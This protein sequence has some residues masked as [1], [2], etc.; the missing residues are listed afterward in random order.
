MER[1][2]TAVVTA[3]NGG[4]LARVYHDYDGDHFVD[5][6]DFA[7][8]RRCWGAALKIGCAAF[9]YD[10][11]KIIDALDWATFADELGG[12]GCPLD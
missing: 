2:E 11:N 6:D 7:W 3:K 5:L 1:D 4:V 12:P 9:D 8:L 10:E